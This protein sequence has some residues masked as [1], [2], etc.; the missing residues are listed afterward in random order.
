MLHSLNFIINPCNSHYDSSLIQKNP[1][2]QFLHYRYDFF[3]VFVSCPWE[4]NFITFGCCSIADAVFR[5][6][7]YK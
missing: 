7:F 2:H 1:H 3:H 4:V 5:A 6:L